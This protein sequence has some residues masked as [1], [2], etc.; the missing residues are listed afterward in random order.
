MAIYWSLLSPALEEI[1]GLQRRPAS[2]YIT[3]GAEAGKGW[4]EK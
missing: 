1:P 4:Y 3:N 2:A